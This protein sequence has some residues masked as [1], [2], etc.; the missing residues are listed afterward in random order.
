MARYE[1]SRPSGA[2]W[3]VALFFG[4][5]S[6]LVT[7]MFFAFRGE[8][9]RVPNAH[10]GK[11]K[12]SAGFQ[13]GLKRPSIFRL[14]SNWF[15]FNPTKLILS[16]VSDN[17]VSEKIEQLY[18]PLDKLNLTFEIVGTFAVS[19]TE[20]KIDSIYD[21]LPPGS[22][23]DQGSSVML[24]S[25]EQVYTTY[26]QQAVRTIAQEI[27]AQYQ[28]TYVLENLDTVSA[29]IQK[30][31]NERLAS[32]PISIKYCG[33][34]QV[35]PPDLI[36]DAQ[37]KAKKR[38]IEIATAQA[39]KM[40]NLTKADAAYQVGLKRQQIELVEAETQVLT[41][42]VLSDAVS[43]AYIAQ[44]ALKV[45][46]GFA[47]NPDATFLL[48]TKVFEDPSSLLGLSKGSIAKLSENKVEHEKKL[49]EATALI[50][51]AKKDALEQ[52]RIEQLNSQKVKED[53]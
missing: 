45:L 30:K 11:I 16:E 42:L 44:R 41:D 6:I 36:V 25:F 40:V 37:A 28:I 27:V 50:E 23:K 9:A 3:F 51:S 14:P 10:V 47:S 49:A 43:E 35:S 13:A 17:K 21:R 1:E 26:G 33:L 5:V 31:V 19:D 46:D 12:T 29:E 8:L 22:A 4:G 52:L 20:E 24:I 18:M 2:L 39:Q 34:G 15:G 32:T 7:I 53:K 48:T 38:E